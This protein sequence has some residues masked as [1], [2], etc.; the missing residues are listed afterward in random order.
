MKKIDRAGI[1][2]MPMG[3]YHG[4]CCVGPSLG[5]S[6]AVTLIDKCPALFW[7]ESYLNPDRPVEEPDNARDFGSAL[8]AMV[9]EPDQVGAKVRICEFGDWRT[10]AA[11]EQRAQARDAGL[12]PVTLTQAVKLAAI[13]KAGEPPAVLSPLPGKSRQ[14]QNLNESMAADAGGLPSA[15]PRADL[16]CDYETQGR[17]LSSEMPLFLKGYELTQCNSQ[18]SRMDS[19]PKTNTLLP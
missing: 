15:A 2:D 10:K 5:G 12:A 18:V 4:N 13:V 14:V 8:H 6:G 16:A 19:G 9:L 7:W 11:Q 1:Y 3:V 17:V